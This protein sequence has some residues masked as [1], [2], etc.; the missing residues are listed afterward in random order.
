MKDY[1]S[2]QLLTT[3]INI[4]SRNIKGDINELLFRYLKKKYEG[5]CNKDGYVKK[6]SLEIV[7]RSV[8]EIKTINGISYVVYKITYKATIL[9][10]VK[11]IQL[12]ITI[13]SITKMGIIGYLKDKDEDTIEDSPF[14][15]IVPKEYF[16]D[17]SIDDDYTVNDTLDTVIE[18][19]RIKY[20]S[21]NI[22]VVAKP[23]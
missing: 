10:P 18:A 3:T 19:A 22:Q 1:E 13:N 12:N 7:N 8:G 15:I 11:G 6:D 21:K 23:V 4:E 9:S 14:I 17:S 16:E 5:V 20:L 2:T